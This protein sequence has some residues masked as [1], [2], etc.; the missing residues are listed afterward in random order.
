[1]SGPNF[2]D[3]MSGNGYGAH[4]P[5]T[6]LSNNAAL[7]VG[8][9]LSFD[10]E[11]CRKSSLP[12]A[13][14]LHNDSPV[15]RWRGQFFIVT[16]QTAHLDFASYLLHVSE[17]SDLSRFALYIVDCITTI[18]QCTSSAQYSYESFFSPL[19]KNFFLKSVFFLICHSL[20]SQ[21]CNCTEFS[22]NLIV[23]YLAISLL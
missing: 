20:F 5:P 17:R 9:V 10:K 16:G 11:C 8:D 18:A 4:L 14:T 3:F 23:C 7:S 2:P 12:A 15:C 13:I 1:M 19:K 22:F 21:F 6:R